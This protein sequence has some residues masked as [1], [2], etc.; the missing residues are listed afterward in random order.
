MEGR[1]RG[2]EAM[3]GRGERRKE[4]R[5]GEKLVWRK[6]GKKNVDK[7]VKGWRER[8]VGEKGRERKVRENT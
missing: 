1:G 5:A 8:E 3:K 6:R 4:S 7:E 2:E